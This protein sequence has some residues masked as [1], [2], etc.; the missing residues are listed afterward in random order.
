MMRRNYLYPTFLTTLV[1]SIFPLLL[2]GS[3]NRRAVIEQVIHLAPYLASALLGFLGLRLN[4]RA[5]FYTALL[6][7]LEGALL[8]ERSFPLISMPVIN[9]GVA[10]ALSLPVGL[11]S[12]FF[13][14]PLFPRGWRGVLFPASVLLPFL[15][16]F[17]GLGNWVGLTRAI[18]QNSFSLSLWGLLVFA[19]CTPWTLN[20]FSKEVRVFAALA[21]LP[22]FWLLAQVIRNGLTG[23]ELDLSIALS[24]LS[25]Q[26]ILC[27]VT[28][29]L[30]WQKVYLDELTGLPNRRALNERLPIMEAPYCVTMFDVD[31]FKK[32]NDSY[33]H[34]Q[35]D[36]V[37][38]LVARIL[39]GEFGANVYRYGGEE[40]CAL[41]EKSEIDEVASFVEKARERLSTREFTIRASPELR[42]NT[43][44]KDRNVLEKGKPRTQVTVSVGV[45]ASSRSLR[46]PEDVLIAADAALYQ[47]K[48]MGRNRVIVAE[49]NSRK[50]YSAG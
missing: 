18:A 2:L 28:F 19:L 42:E 21:C 27:A 11:A 24:F 14:V 9:A 43:S 45:A 17:V 7:G 35:G 30:Y 6:V 49:F 48:Q 36:H 47:A 33:G 31:H 38:R 39:E 44:S 29:R 3:A 34:E 16:A 10:V 25:A 26:I 37:L 23:R 15:L 20:R 46:R 13:L 5:I 4:E 1:L 40:F 41:F 32:F 22:I 12:L 8:R 50:K